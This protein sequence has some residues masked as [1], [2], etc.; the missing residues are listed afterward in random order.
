MTT[1]DRIAA[2][3]RQM[4]NRG[5]LL[6]VSDKG[7]VGNGMVVVAGFKSFREAVKALKIAGFAPQGGYWKLAA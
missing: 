6:S 5:A 4:P 3:Y 2:L 7:I 1:L